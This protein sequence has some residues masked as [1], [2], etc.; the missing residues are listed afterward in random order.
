MLDEVDADFWK[1]NVHLEEEDIVEPEEAI[2]RKITQIKRCTYLFSATL[3]I[4]NGER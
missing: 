2:D 3:A 4:S 1:S